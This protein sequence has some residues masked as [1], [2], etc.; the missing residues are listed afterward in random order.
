MLD[1]QDEAVAKFHLGE[2]SVGRLDPHCLF[3]DYSNNHGLGYRFHLRVRQFSII[4]LQLLC[5]LLIAVALP[6]CVLSQV[7]L[8][9][10][11]TA[12]IDPS[13]TGHYRLS[14]VD[15]LPLELDVYLK[16]NRYVV[17]AAPKDIF[18]MTLHPLQD[19]TYLA[20]LRKTG[21]NSRYIYFLSRKSDSG[22]EIN[23]IPCDAGCEPI[24]DLESLNTMA[25][26]GAS[27]F[28]EQKSA[29]AEKIAE[30]GR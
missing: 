4:R 19:S 22:L 20:Q 16:E 1:W 11:K 3:A 12:I 23:F 14:G 10:D 18:I 9:E 17:V 29:K 13:L 26:N 30:L 28:D 24:G 25:A 6:G 7:P 15:K 8:L 5:L 27:H 21:G 2:N